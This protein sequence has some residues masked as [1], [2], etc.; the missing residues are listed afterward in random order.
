MINQTNKWEEDGLPRRGLDDCR[1]AH[2][3]GIEIDVCTF[4]CSLRFDI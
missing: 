4:F 3:C 2:S 1:L